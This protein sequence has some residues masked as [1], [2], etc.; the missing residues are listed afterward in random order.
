ME[1]HVFVRLWNLAQGHPCMSMFIRSAH[2]D[3]HRLQVMLNYL[4][5]LFPRLTS[6]GVSCFGRPPVSP[7]LKVVRDIPLTGCLQPL[8]FTRHLSVLS[9]HY[10]KGVDQYQ[11]C[12][13]G[14]PHP[15]CVSAHTTMEEA[16]AI[17]GH[18]TQKAFASVV[19]PGPLQPWVT[20]LD[21]D[22]SCGEPGGPA[23]SQSVKYSLGFYY[24]RAKETT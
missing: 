17:P 21:S 4:S 16:T 20:G 8:H 14:K 23:L 12:F 2:L 6:V 15:Y 9:P 3:Q 18:K 5:T 19:G 22:H 1:L 24:Y 7:G 13:K 10:S 11:Q